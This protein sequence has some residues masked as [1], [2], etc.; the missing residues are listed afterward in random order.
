LTRPHGAP[1]AEQPDPR[2]L[3]TDRHGDEVVIGAGMRYVGHVDAAYR[4][5][6]QLHHEGRGL[7]LV[8]AWIAS[9]MASTS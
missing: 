8:S 3:V 9:G 2:A 6:V 1:L 4:L 7:S 5:G